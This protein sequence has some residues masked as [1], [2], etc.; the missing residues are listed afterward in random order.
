MVN[1]KI[2]I[3][4][5][6]EIYDKDSVFASIALGGGFITK[7]FLIDNEI[8]F[9]GSYA[10]YNILFQYWRLTCSHGGIRYDVL[11]GKSI[12]SFSEEKSEYIEKLK[13]ILK[14]LFY[15][16][17][18]QQDFEEAKN[19]S[20]DT[21]E[22][23]YK[24]GKFRGK[25][26]IFEFSD[27]NKKFELRELINDIERIDFDTFISCA[28]TLL[29]PGNIYLYING[30]VHEA[31]LIYDAVESVL[32]G[33]N[34]SVEVKNNYYDPY[35][36]QDAHL[37]NLARENFS[38]SAVTFDFL[39]PGVTNFTKQVILDFKAAYLPYSNVDIYV[40][41]LDANIIFE[42][43]TLQP[44]KPLIYEEILKEQF[45][46]LKKKILQ[47]YFT[48]LKKYPELFTMMGADMM[49][50]DISLAQYISFIGSC[51]YELYCELCEKSHFKIT[52]AQV[53]LKKEAVEFV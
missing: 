21:F 51:T 14:K 16:E 38:L 29:V 4:L 18:N 53:V 26:K 13:Y 42:N 50:N 23:R 19:I 31:E 33:R 27:L 5:N 2:K 17:Y 1:R 28:K 49:V 39:H 6:N 11:R 36:K 24:S 8:T 43:E 48:L 52:E 32:P 41:S 7:D 25:L 30:A 12:I 15:D 47:R 34:H 37:L 3:E 45:Q 20:K 46:L 44:V 40:D 9:A 22:R 35:L 10:F